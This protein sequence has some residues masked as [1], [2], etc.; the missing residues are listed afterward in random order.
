MHGTCM[1]TSM[2]A[3]LRWSFAVEFIDSRVVWTGNTYFWVSQ[4]SKSCCN[5]KCPKPTVAYYSRDFFSPGGPCLT[6]WQVLCSSWSL[7][8]PFCRHASMTT[9]IR[10]NQHRKLHTDSTVPV[11][12]LSLA[13]AISFSFGEEEWP[14][15][16]IH[17]QSSFFCLRK[18]VAELTSVL[19]FLC[20]MWDTTTAW[21]DEQC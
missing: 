16:H 2:D 3:M 19:I 21:L 18:I 14:W 10:R 13:R 11:G 17:C 4:V 6:Y 12:H 20:F 7:R 9:G 5:T 1:T 15:A 8:D